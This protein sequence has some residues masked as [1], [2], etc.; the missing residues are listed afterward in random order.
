MARNS[1][2]QKVRRYLQIHP[3]QPPKVVAIKTGATASLVSTVKSKMKKDQQKAA[4]SSDDE[5]PEPVRKR[6]EAPDRYPRLDDAKEIV[7]LARAC[8]RIVKQAGGPARA[9][10]FLKWAMTVEL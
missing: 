9:Y 10:K 8:K 3:D 1:L 2:S 7:E 4:A 5:E 6:R